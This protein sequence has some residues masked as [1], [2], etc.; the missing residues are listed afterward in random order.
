[1]AKYTKPST[2]DHIRF[3]FELYKR[4]PQS[5][6][7][8]AQELKRSLDEAGLVRDIR[9]IQRNLDVVT[10]YFDVEKD[11]RDKPYGYS[12]RSNQKRTLAAREAIILALAEQNLKEI[13]PAELVG[14]IA[15]TF[16]EAQIQLSPIS[17]GSTF[18]QPKKVVLAKEHSNTASNVIS[19][20]IFEKLC[21]GVYHNRWITIT[22]KTDKEI[23]EN[24]KS[25]DIMPLGILLN[26]KSLSLVYMDKGQSVCKE[27]PLSQ[28][29]DIRVST[30]TFDYPKSFDLKDYSSSLSTEPRNPDLHQSEKP[31]VDLIKPN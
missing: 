7:V 2:A 17:K 27:I 29:D 28:I 9:T 5:R 1:M 10:R 6:K 4:I 23:N 19:S 21:V 14:A 20:A 16:T 8:T 25:Y 30:F 12:R 13:L 3:A 24:I 15:S 22:R 18:V 31:C 11:T 26:R